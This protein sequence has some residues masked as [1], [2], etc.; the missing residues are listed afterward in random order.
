MC[1]TEM[2]KMESLVTDDGK[3]SS[4]GILSFMD[5]LDFEC[6]GGAQPIYGCMDREALNYNEEATAQRDGDVI[7]NGSTIMIGDCEY[8]ACDYM[9][10]IDYD[11]KKN[12]GR[13][14]FLFRRKKRK[15]GEEVI[16]FRP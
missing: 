1:T 2:S 4:P 14:V 6:N 5:E 13:Y 9:V 16:T 12:C 3:G 11:P 15:R 7:E 10:N 8:C